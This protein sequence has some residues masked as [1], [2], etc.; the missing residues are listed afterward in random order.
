[1]LKNGFIHYILI[2]ILVMKNKLKP[3]WVGSTLQKQLQVSY[4]CKSEKSK[5]SRKTQATHCIKDGK[6]V[7]IG[8]SGNSQVTDKLWQRFLILNTH[9]SKIQYLNSQVEGLYT[10]AFVSLG[11]SQF[12]NYLITQRNSKYFKVMQKKPFQSSVVSL[13]DN[14]KSGLCVNVLIFHDVRIPRRDL[15][16]FLPKEL[17]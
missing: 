1:M 8:K 11:E 14:E 10:S 4:G 3:C 17:H 5:V 16:K 2:V 13:I 7:S 15:N 6:L 9:D 12:K